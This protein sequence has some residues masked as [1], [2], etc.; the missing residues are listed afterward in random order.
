MFSINS[1]NDPDPSL[2]ICSLMK[3]WRQSI[4]KPPEAKRAM[5]SPSNILF[6]P[7]HNKTYKMACAPSEDS[8]QPGHPPR[9]TRVFA[10]RMKKACP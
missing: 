7:A 8:D 6:E 10:V 5:V 9:L 3:S 1:N 4:G 2:N